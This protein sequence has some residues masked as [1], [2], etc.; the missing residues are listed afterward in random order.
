[1]QIESSFCFSD[2]L[3]FSI[4]LLW[5]FHLFLHQDGGK[6]CSSIKVTTG[7]P[8]REISAHHFCFQ[9]TTLI[10]REMPRPL[11]PA[12]L[13]VLTVIR[14]SFL[15]SSGPAGQCDGCQAPAEV[16]TNYRWRH[17]YHTSITPLCLSLSDCMCVFA[18]LPL[19]L[20]CTS[21]AI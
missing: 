17:Y 3:S 11:L 9:V 20:L 1:M 7:T 18:L 14:A 15:F 16:E 19:C 5:C 6:Q 10:S 8:L 21:L 12:S 2:A 4:C 13:Q